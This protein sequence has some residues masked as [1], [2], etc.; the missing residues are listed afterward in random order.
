MND[1][2]DLVFAGIGVAICFCLLTLS[3]DL[4]D[5]NDSIMAGVACENG[6]L[7]VVAKGSNPSPPA[8][9]EE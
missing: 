3:D 2:S 8:P 1:L 7:S 5:I 9:I 4:E 6:D